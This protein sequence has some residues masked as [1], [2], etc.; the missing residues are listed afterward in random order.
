MTVEE[1]LL[2]KIKVLPMNRKHEVLDFAEFLE[3]KEAKPKPRQ[4]AYGMLSDLNIKITEE[5]ISEARKEMWKNFP[6]EH[7]FDKE[8]E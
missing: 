7:F 4:S 3:E 1:I 6:R 2:E 5:D 8:A